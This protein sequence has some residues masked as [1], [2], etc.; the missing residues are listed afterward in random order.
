MAIENFRAAKRNRNDEYYTK[1]ADIEQ[2]LEHYRDYFSG[3]TVYCPCDDYRESNFIK[4]FKRN[5]HNLHLKA[6]L[7]S[8]LNIGSGAYRYKYDGEFQ[9]AY[10]TATGD[11]NSAEVEPMLTHCDIIVTNPPFSKLRELYKRIRPYKKDFLLMAP[12]NAAVYSDM[13]PDLVNGTLR[14]DIKNMRYFDTP[15]GEKAITNVVW[16]TTLEPPKHTLNLTENYEEGKYDR[17]DLFKDI[18]NVDRSNKIPKDYKGAMGVPLSF[19]KWYDPKEWEI[20]GLIDPP[21]IQGKEKFVRVAVK[22]R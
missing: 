9:I 22:R 11:F 10:P 6:L 1:M 7:A 3:K 18:I 21:K 4:Y 17:Y 2:D 5:F 14:V 20:L 19:L 8:N 16:L 12:L 15:Q 13:L